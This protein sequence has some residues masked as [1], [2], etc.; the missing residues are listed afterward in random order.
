[1]W[2]RSAEC[3]CMSTKPGQSIMP[4]PST[5]SAAPS[6]AEVGLH[7]GDPVAADADVRPPRRTL[8]GVDVGATDQEVE[9]HRERV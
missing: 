1:M 3:A 5:S 7:G 2:E 4:V 6:G 9:V 8:A